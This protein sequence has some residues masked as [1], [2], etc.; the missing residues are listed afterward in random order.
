MY[1]RIA[2]TFTASLQRLTGAEQKAVKTT[3]FDL[4]L[5]PSAP[6]LSFHKLD[7]AKDP[8]F[9][10][11]RV[12]ADI[13]LIVHRSADSLLLCYAD[14]HDDAY[15]WAARRRIE[16]HPATGAAQL[17]EIRERVEETV[18]PPAPAAPPVAE[19][20]FRSGE[21]MARF[22]PPLF[23]ELANEDLLAVGVPREWLFDVA[24]ASEMNF[25]DLADHLPGEAVEALLDYAATGVLPK[26]GVREAGADPFDHPDAQRRF[27]IL[28]NI[29]ELERALDFPWEK[30]VVFLHPDQRRLVSKVFNGPARVS[31]SAGTGKTVVALHRAMTLARRDGNPRVLL[32]TF[33]PTLA[34]ALQAKLGLLSGNEPGVSERITVRAMSDVACDLYAERFGP[35]LLADPALIAAVLSEA[36]AGET[37]ARFAPAFLAAEWREVVDAWSV[38]TWEEY[39]D[40]P[41][42]GRRTRVGGKQRQA[43]WHIFERVRQSLAGLGV[44]TLADIYHALARHFADGSAGPFDYAVVDE[45]QDIGVP[46]LRFLAALAGGS[47]DGLFFAG[48]LGQRIFQP[49]FSWKSLGVDIRGRAHTLKVNYRTSHQIR[50]RAD[51]LLPDVVADADGEGESRTGTVSLFDGPPPKIGT[52]SGPVSEAE[53]V[54]LWIAE[55]IDEGVPPG[56]IA[57]F[58][59]ST[60]QLP[61]A[62]AAVEAA[63]TVACLLDE[64]SD[65]DGEAVAIGTMHAAKGL[66]FRV[67]AVIACDDEVIPLQERIDTAADDAELEEVYHTERH[68]LYVACT[69]PRDHLWVSGV[70]P[71]SEFLDDMQGVGSLT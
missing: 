22:Y 64:N 7:R 52:F 59:R 54:G 37:S 51:R 19:G 27:R 16:T 65:A 23:I 12:N 5:A 45:A 39:R 56:E 47:A 55:H 10:S 30:W 43:L 63:G 8:H 13:R 9:W 14:H 38:R 70:A 4:Q 49:P 24:N 60:A 3:A 29:D 35:P 20:A 42:L 41:R 62:R 33:S 31:G 26:P 61:R 28:D 34:K 67:V 71:V 25:F 44:V 57:V 58:V 53:A 40:I 21:G 50:T 69:R 32:T 1:F 68:L 17:V 11:V 2:D 66:E 18:I 36:A 15:A 46:A 6:G 48:D